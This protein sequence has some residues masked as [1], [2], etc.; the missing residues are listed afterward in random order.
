M[1]EVGF[2]AAT[3][4][5]GLDRSKLSHTYTNDAKF[6]ATILD[7]L[8]QMPWICAMIIQLP[9]QVSVPFGQA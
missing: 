1:C 4:P 7:L 6:Q 3:A 5:A 2:N 8:G 9:R